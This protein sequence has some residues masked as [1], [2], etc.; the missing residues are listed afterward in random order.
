MKGEK[1]IGQKVEQKSFHL[2]V[3]KIINL[4]RG[5]KARVNSDGNETSLIQWS[6]S[7]TQLKVFKNVSKLQATPFSA[8][9]IASIGLLSDKFS[10]I[11]NN[12]KAPQIPRVKARETVEF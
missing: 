3:L 6:T 11:A 10:I 2:E 8:W 5:R 12:V 4:L 1:T 9:C 7:G